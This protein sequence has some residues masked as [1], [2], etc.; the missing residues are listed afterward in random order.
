MQEV[1]TTASLVDYATLEGGRSITAVLPR[2]QIAAALHGDDSAQLWFELEREEDEQARL[3]TI[4]MVSGDLAEMLRRSTGDE[5]VLALDGDAAAGLFD[6]PDVEAHGMRGAFAI[7]VVAGA[8]M[9]PA[10]LAA[11]PQVSSLSAKAQVSGLAA[12]TQV[13]SLAAKAQITGVA[14]KT[15]VSKSLVV[16]AGGVKLLKGPL[17]R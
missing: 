7:A 6:D 2:S 3:L 14:A 10:G 11:N 1:T 4:D 12:T 9:A 8:M 16:K 5:V 15:Q 13:S 17:A